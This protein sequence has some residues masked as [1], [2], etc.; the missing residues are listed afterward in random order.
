MA[1]GKILPTL[2][3]WQMTN[4]DRGAGP[5]LHYVKKIRTR[6]YPQSP[7]LNTFFHFGKV[8]SS[9]KQLDYAHKDYEF[10]EL[11]GPFG[12][13][14]QIEVTYMNGDVLT[15]DAEQQSVDI[16]LKTMKKKRQDMERD[17]WWSIQHSH[18]KLND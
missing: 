14:A 9:R 18:M 3:K 6:Y 12:T 10:E 7:R 16:M 13:R 4:S 11:K 1:K 17:L 5:I 8:V 15:F 2:Y